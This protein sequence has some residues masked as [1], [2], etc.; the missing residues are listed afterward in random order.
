MR[1]C[2]QT[3]TPLVKSSFLHKQRRLKLVSYLFARIKVQDST[4]GFAQT[5]TKGEEED[6]DE[7]GEE[8]EAEEDVVDDDDVVEEERNNTSAETEGQS[9]SLDDSDKVTDEPQNPKPEEQKDKPVPDGEQKADGAE[10]SEPSTTGEE[11][12]CDG[13]IPANGV[14]DVEAKSQAVSNKKLSLFR[15]LSFSRSKQNQDRDQ[16]PVEGVIS[17]DAASPGEPHSAPSAA[18]SS[19]TEPIGDRVQLTSQP[20]GARAPRSGACTI[21]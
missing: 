19:N 2:D 11:N 17:G 4:R 1:L 13:T 7:D 21:L 15:R 10:T 6:E 18:A 14:T 5:W 16:T 20:P 9:S 3:L 8:E 12:T